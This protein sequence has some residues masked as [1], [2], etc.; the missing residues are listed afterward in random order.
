MLLCL[1]LHLN[2]KT[3]HF[4]WKIVCL[5]HNLLLFQWNPAINFAY[6]LFFKVYSSLQLLV[7][8]ALCSA[9]SNSKIY[10]SLPIT[11][12]LEQVLCY[13]AVFTTPLTKLT[14]SMYL[15]ILQQMIEK[16]K[17]RQEYKHRFCRI[18]ILSP[19]S[20]LNSWIIFSLL[21]V[22]LSYSRPWPGRCTNLN[23]KL[24][25]LGVILTAT[26]PAVAA[27]LTAIMCVTFLNYFRQ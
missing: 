22:K 26:L 21:E 8:H 13:V 4:N 1:L 25:F 5:Y 14:Y 27:T 20:N 6:N 24:G 23:K 12:N 11:A 19:S 2:T 17:K 10:N 3:V 16:K 7:L 18:H 15:L 9:P